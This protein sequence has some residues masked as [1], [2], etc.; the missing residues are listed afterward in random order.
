M[1]IEDVEL[2]YRKLKHT[3][4]SDSTYSFIRGQLA[5]FE[6]EE[7]GDF[8]SSIELIK[9]KLAE[10][11]TKINEKD[12]DFFNSL[13]EAID[14]WYLPKKIESK[15][16]GEDDPTVLSN[17]PE[18]EEEIRVTRIYALINADI[19]LHLISVLW[20]LKGG[21]YLESE[22]K[23]KPLGNKLEMKTDKS[24]I[25]GGLKLFKFYPK[26][27]QKWRDDAFKKAKQIISEKENVLLV[28]LD[29]K[30]YY[31]SVKLDFSK[32][33]VKL[34]NK[35]KGKSELEDLSFLTSILEKIHEKYAS[36]F[37]SK[38]IKDKI[39]QG[40]PIGLHS[41]AVIG[42]WFLKEF[43][44]KVRSTINPAYYARY[45]DDIMIVISNPNISDNE[46]SDIGENLNDNFK[47]DDINAWVFLHYFIKNKILKDKV[48]EKQEDS[49]DSLIDLSVK[50]KFESQTKN[51]D[52]VIDIDGK[53]NLQIQS[54]KSKFYYFD[55]NHPTA[56]L[57]KIEK[58]LQIES[59]EFRYLPE[60]DKLNQDFYS[61]AHYL[62]FEGSVSKLRNVSG[63]GVNSFG[64]SKYLA[65]KIF[66]TL[67][68]ER[69]PDLKASQQINIFFKGSRAI[70]TAKLWEK[71]ATFFVASKDA[72]GL[73][74]FVRSIDN[75]IKKTKFVEEGRI[76]EDKSANIKETLYKL[77]LG[78]VSMAFALDTSFMKDEDSKKIIEEIIKKIENNTI[79]QMITLLKRSNMIRHNYVSSPLINFT[80]TG[81]EKHYSYL[82]PD[83]FPKK[84]FENDFSIMDCISPRFVN[85]HE[86]VLSLYRNEL[87]NNILEKGEFLIIEDIMKNAK[88]IHKS[89]NES[90]L[91]I[92]INFTEPSILSVNGVKNTS[93]KRIEFNSH[94]SLS[95]LT[96]GLVN[97]K[98]N[99]SH[100]EKSYLQNP[101]FD[102]KRKQ[103]FNSL[104]NLVQKT[105]RESETKKIDVL[106]LPE[107]SVP[108]N[109]LDWVCDYA[110]K[111]QTIMIFGVEHWIRNNIAY[112]LL[113]CL[114][115]F[116]IKGVEK[117]GGVYNGLL[118]I[119]RIKNHYAPDEKLILES[120]RYTIPKPTPSE[121]F[122]IKWKGISFSIFNCFELAD[123]QQRALFRSLVDVLFA[124]EYNVDTN[125]YSNIVESIVR[126][127]HCYFVQSNNSKNGDSRITRPTKSQTMN[128]V[129]IKG[130]ENDSIII[131]TIDIDALRKFQIQNYNG[132]ETSVFKPT[133]P[134]FDV[135]NAEK[136]YG[137]NFNTNKNKKNGK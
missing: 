103:K 108:F 129:Q 37:G 26:L 92:D 131:D 14:F 69:K 9:P 8:I 121:Y 72:K 106:I 125:Y 48:F 136:R 90:E 22:M 19:R 78:S 133:P 112:N 34:K 102:T 105:E 49:K 109:A 11:L 6:Q 137:N 66:S 110:K 24:G 32:L 61:E 29:V 120:Y 86:I 40:L 44:D 27:Y 83:I 107:L 114:L 95:N 100:I 31:P 134:G 101:V 39:I 80:K 21:Y 3:I 111:N 41:S 10:L 75:A 84:D 12:E 25:V 13:V 116:Q 99:D 81:I 122:L 53:D 55:K 113:A 45:V 59:S 123:I 127:V 46:E 5:A 17:S 85:F 43:D 93:I 20:I 135:K 132:P 88:K 57:D 67:Q 98:L 58:E 82:D 76:L 117:E 97:M 96:I 30:E 115:P 73:L 64:A 35:F 15:L 71:T 119:F 118:P 130:G 1:K 104:L 28:S 94:K 7:S 2:A 70:E 62:S 124:C 47:K 89:I 63:F 33:G 56:L 4:Y 42:N 36:K 79:Q 51:V 52:Y 128:Q 126:D 87:S 65:K 68:S 16:K 91:E 50:N 60:N 38:G 77:L 74:Y 18:N 54:E 23:V